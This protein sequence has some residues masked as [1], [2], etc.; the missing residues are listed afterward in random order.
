V[1]PLARSYVSDVLLVDDKAIRQARQALW[2]STR[3][4]TEPAGAVT[5][6][7]LITGAY[8]PEPGERVALVL[9]GANTTL[10]DFQAPVAGPG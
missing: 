2:R 6:A 1:F 7:A 5:S 4:I 8:R 10:S 9:S 3:M